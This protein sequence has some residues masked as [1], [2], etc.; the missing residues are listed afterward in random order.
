MPRRYFMEAGGGGTAEVIGI[1]R[2][3]GVDL[4]DVP[5][6]AEFLIVYGAIGN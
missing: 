1:D 3:T 4:G 2:T 6:M 5:T